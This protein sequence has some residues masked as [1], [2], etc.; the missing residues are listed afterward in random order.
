M[1]TINIS[2]TLTKEIE[3]LIQDDWIKREFEYKS[4]DDFVI[5]SIESCIEADKDI[6]NIK[7]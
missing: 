3:E 5:T 7:I 1:T 4:V 6:A 2:K